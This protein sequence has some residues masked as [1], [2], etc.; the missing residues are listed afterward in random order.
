MTVVEYIWINSNNEIKTKIK[1]ICL[2][3]NNNK[4]SLDNFPNWNYD[5]SRSMEKINGSEV[6]LKPVAFYKSPFKIVNFIVL[7]DTWINNTTPSPFNHRVNTINIL[8][9]T[10]TYLPKIG[11]EQE[12]F[13][14]R[15]NIPLSFIDNH[16]IKNTY[17]SIGNNSVFIKNI[18]IRDIILKA[19]DNC[20]E[21][22]LELIGYNLESKPS[23]FKFKILADGINAADQLYMM[24]YII[25]RTL[26]DYNC[27][28]DL[29]PNPIENYISKCATTFSTHDM[30]QPNGIKYI[31]EAITYLQKK[32]YRHLLFYGDNQLSH[33]LNPIFNYKNG[34]RNTC[35]RIPID[36]RNNKCGFLEDRRPFSNIDPY[37][38]T[39][40]LLST[41]CKIKQNYYIDKNNIDDDDDNK[42]PPMNPID[43]MLQD[44]TIPGWAMEMLIK[45]SRIEQAKNKKNN[46]LPND[47]KVDNT[48]PNDIIVDDTLPNDIIVDDTLSNDIIVDD[49]L[50]SEL[51]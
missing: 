12:F 38:I 1:V 43:E 27:Y 2:N 51:D 5:V 18:S 29:R 21:A 14:S 9:K 11:F 23:Q 17:C 34:N 46:T 22:G 4:I 15:D 20:L 45:E 13:L 31:E 39:T 37:I 16:P 3:Y 25:N 49:S 30:R 44:M 50:T 19:F 36:V 32:H 10:K 47:I 8:E 6:I 26:E 35:I 42:K 24:R 41:I 28:L 40:L 48:L 7:C 33:K